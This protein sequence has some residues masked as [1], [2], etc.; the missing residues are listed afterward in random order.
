MRSAMSAARRDRTAGTTSEV[1]LKVPK[2]RQRIVRTDII[3][4]LPEEALIEMYLARC[5]AKGI[6]RYTASPRA[7][8]GIRWGGASF[9]S[10]SGARVRRQAADHLRRCLI[11]SDR[12]GE[13]RDR[14][15]RDRAIILIELSSAVG[16]EFNFFER[17]SERCYHDFPLYSVGSASASGMQCISPAVFETSD[18]ILVPKERRHAL[19]RVVGNV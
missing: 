10:I 17:H 4:R 19:G 16:S 15:D 14:L 8:K 5:P 9:S 12:R 2:L 18:E 7:R 6:K 3:V 11:S 1:R 13:I